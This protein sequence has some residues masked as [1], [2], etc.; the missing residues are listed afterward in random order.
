MTKQLLLLM[1][2]VEALR[3]YCFLS[4]LL[5]ISEISYLLTPYSVDNLVPFANCKITV[6]LSFKERMDR[7]LFGHVINLC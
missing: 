3:F 6:W 2:P 4:L 5:W 7:L 1:S